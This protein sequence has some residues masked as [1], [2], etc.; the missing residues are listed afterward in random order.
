[1]FNIIKLVIIFIYFLGYFSLKSKYIGKI[2]RHRFA[3]KKDIKKERGE[4]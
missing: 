2:T 1:M 4:E 3:Q